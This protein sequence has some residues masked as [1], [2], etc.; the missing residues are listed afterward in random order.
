MGLVNAFVYIVQIPAGIVNEFCHLDTGGPILDT[1]TTDL[2]IQV[3]GPIS[4]F[5]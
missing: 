4:L 3:N 5:L 2:S 1:G